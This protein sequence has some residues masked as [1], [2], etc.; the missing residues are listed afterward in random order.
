MIVAAALIYFFSARAS[1]IFQKNKEGSEF[2]R[3]SV[4][5][6]FD[7]ATSIGFP[8]KIQNWKCVLGVSTTAAHE[9]SD[10]GALIR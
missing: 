10:D 2:F 5:T 4:S 9:I 8:Y 6:Y 7:S 1:A 3:D